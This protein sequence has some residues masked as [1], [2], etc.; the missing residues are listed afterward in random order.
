MAI[1]LK[2][3]SEW[4]HGWFPYHSEVV[5]KSQGASNA[6][7]NL[8]TDVNGEV[9]LEDKPVIPDVSGKI[10]TAGTGLSKSGTTLNHSNSVSAQSSAVFKKVKYD[11]QG[12]ITGTADVAGTDL[13][14]HLHSS[15]DVSDSNA[16]YSYIHTGLP[17][18][19]NSVH[20][21]FMDIDRV[22]GNLSSIKAIEV[23][24]ELPIASAST[25][26]KIYIFNDSQTEK[27]DA[28]Y[29]VQNGSSYSWATLDEN[30]LDSLDIK[31]SDITGK[32][33]IFPPSSHTHGNISNDGKIG[34]TNNQILITENNGVITTTNAIN[35]QKTVDNGSYTNFYTLPNPTQNM[36]NSAIDTALGNKASSTH[37]H[38][39]ITDDGKIGTSSGVVIT[40]NDGTIDVTYSLGAGLITYRY[41]GQ[42]ISLT[43]ILTQMLTDIEGKASSVHTHSISDVSNLQSSLNNKQDIGDCITSISLVPKSSDDT[44]AIRLYYGDEPTNNS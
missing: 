42:P 38:G 26:G 29:T 16:D 23:V 35:T 34:T 32:P 2:G 19:P 20:D 31:W 22:I 9:T 10:D 44:G 1:D 37:N 27:V 39:N 17:S 12:H 41:Q 18:T 14:S 6:G 36:I 21:T 33:S 4:L 5:G 43:T 15:T 30:I 3:I 7:K 8:V 13:P 25:M 11:A 24:T 28:K 40:Q